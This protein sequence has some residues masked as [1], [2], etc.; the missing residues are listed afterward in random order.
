M[1]QRDDFKEKH[2]H[3]D[4]GMEFTIV[5][6]CLPRLPFAATPQR[7][8][9]VELRVSTTPVE[10]AT[11][12]GAFDVEGVIVGDER[13]WSVASFRWLH[14][15]PSA[16]ARVDEPASYHLLLRPTLD[17]LAASVTQA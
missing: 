16:A 12:A 7:G 1:Q 3:K 5:M 9:F 17:R 13:R 8:G 15:S 6:S 4:A 14:A 2:E 11:G 10:E